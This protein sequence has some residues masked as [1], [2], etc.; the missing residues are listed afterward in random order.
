MNNLVIRCNLSGNPTIADYLQQVRQTTLDAYAHQDLPFDLIIDALN[1]IRRIHEAIAEPDGE[2]K[3]ADALTSSLRSFKR[4]LKT[5][6][7]THAVAVFPFN[8][9]AVIVSLLLLWFVPATNHTSI[10]SPPKTSNTPSTER[11]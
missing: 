10:A 5:H 4:A 6:R 8:G 11:T 7:P 9:R 2:Q 3:V 1:I